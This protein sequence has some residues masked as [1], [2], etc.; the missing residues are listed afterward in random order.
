MKD[1]FKKFKI[2]G[3]EVERVKKVTKK[4]YKRKKKYNL[5]YCNDYRK[6]IVK[7]K[8]NGLHRKMLIYPLEMNKAMKEL[9]KEKWVQDL[10]ITSETA[11]FVYAIQKGFIEGQFNTDKKDE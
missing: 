1:I 8:E 7:D 2:V 3:E 4:D 6:R 11:M 9:L 10:D 5:K